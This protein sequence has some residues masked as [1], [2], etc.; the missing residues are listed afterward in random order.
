MLIST[1]SPSTTTIS[2]FEA[3]DGNIALG[4]T[5]ITYFSS[6]LRGITYHISWIIMH[7]F[8]S[9]WRVLDDSSSAKI[10]PILS[11]RGNLHIICQ[12]SIQ[13]DFA[14]YFF[15]FSRDTR[16]CCNWIALWLGN[17]ILKIKDKNNIIFGSLEIN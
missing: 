4:L 3:Q 12:G 7:S 16:C 1:S 14:F 11:Y 5:Y 17:S 8:T 15:I 13:I 10:A 6:H 2:C 9:T